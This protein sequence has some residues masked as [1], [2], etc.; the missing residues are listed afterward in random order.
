[1]I[2]VGLPTSAILEVN[3]AGKAYSV[4]ALLQDCW[5]AALLHHLV[6]LLHHLLSLL[7]HLAPFRAGFGQTSTLLIVVTARKGFLVLRSISSTELSHDSDHRLIRTLSISIQSFADFHLN[8]FNNA[9][10]AY[11]LYVLQTFPDL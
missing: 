11:I 2:H 3:R 7:H 8:S 9:F 5:L 1:M 6:S 10:T 4:I